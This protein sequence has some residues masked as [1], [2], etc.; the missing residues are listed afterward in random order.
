MTDVGDLDRNWPAIGT[1]P[2][3]QSK[4]GHHEEA[5][6]RW[7]TCQQVG[8]LD[9]VADHSIDGVRSENDASQTDESEEVDAVG[10]VEPFGTT[11]STTLTSATQVA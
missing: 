1:T 7:A 6:D 11:K 2:Q 9:T 10:H 5:D 4:G 8:G 3:A